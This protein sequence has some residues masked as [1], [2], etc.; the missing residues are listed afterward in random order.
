MTEFLEIWVAFMI[1]K[2]KYACKLRMQKDVRWFQ[3]P[4][5]AIHT[6]PS[7]IWHIT[8]C[9]TEEEK[10]TI[11]SYMVSFVDVHF[12]LPSSWNNTS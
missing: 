10:V 11:M 7:Y 5:I 1:I 6:Y 8:E 3:Y 2:E 9:I 12:V 4:D